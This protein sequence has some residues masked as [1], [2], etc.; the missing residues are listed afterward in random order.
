VAS[1]EGT[2][3]LEWREGRRRIQK[4][5]GTSPR[6][7][8]DA[9]RVQCGQLLVHPVPNSES[10]P[11]ADGKITTA[12]EV[13]LLQ[14]KATKN[15]ATYRAY[16]TDLE[17][18]AAK[19]AGQFV[20]QVTRQDI[21]RVFGVGR[22]EKLN[23]KSIN[24]RVMVGVMALRNAGAVIQL[25]KGDWPRTTDKGV[26]IYEHDELRTFFAACDADER[27]LFQTFLCSGFRDRELATLSWSDVDWRQH[28]LRVRSKPEYGLCRSHMKSAALA[29]PRH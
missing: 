9:W 11:A 7:A 29:F 5:V 17:W 20:G 18:F 25:K 19:I 13:F 8:L 23:Q 16:G 28:T 26:E 24:R 2:Y 12:I 14:V 6:E 15:V 27:L 10:A 22:D 1:T 4:P 21:L 3:Y